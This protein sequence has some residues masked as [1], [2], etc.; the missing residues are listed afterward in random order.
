MYSAGYAYESI[1]SAKKQKG[2]NIVQCCSIEN[3]KGA[4]ATDLVQW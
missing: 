4:I 2:T 3:Q 1:L